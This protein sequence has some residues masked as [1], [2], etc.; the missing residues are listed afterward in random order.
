MTISPC[1]MLSLVDS[2]LNLLI[3][4]L[5]SDI[6]YVYDVCCREQQQCVVWPKCAAKFGP[7]LLCRPYKG[8]PSLPCTF[9]SLPTGVLLSYN[10]SLLKYSKLL[11][12]PN[13]HWTRCTR[14]INVWFRVSFINKPTVYVNNV[15]LLLLYFT[16]TI[17]I[18][19]SENIFSFFF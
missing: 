1:S 10:S 17:D 14:V 13:Y 5:E 4:A 15:V 12:I 16:G 7:K 9:S 6:C 18:I 19:C 11:N 2:N 8:F 3:D